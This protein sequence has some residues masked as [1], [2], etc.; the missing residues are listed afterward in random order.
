MYKK[1]IVES[2][3]SSLKETFKINKSGYFCPNCAIEWDRPTMYAHILFNAPYHKFQIYINCNECH[4]TTPAFDDAN[5]AT[6]NVED[7][8]ISKENNLFG[9]DLNDFRKT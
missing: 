5:R 6:D 2:F 9:G 8:W 3:F 4:N 1:R 7:L